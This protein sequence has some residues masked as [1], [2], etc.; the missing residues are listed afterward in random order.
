MRTSDARRSLQQLHCRSMLRM[1]FSEVLLILCLFQKCATETEAPVVITDSGNVAGTRIEIG[2]RKVDA[3][4]GIPYAEPP[5]GELRFQ[6]A[7]P[8]KPWNGTYQAT[9]KPTPCRQLLLPVFAGIT[10][11]YSSASEDCLYL[12]VW[13]P[14]SACESPESCE[15]NLPVVVFV[16]GNV[17][18][19]ADSSLFLNDPANFVALTDVVFVTFNYR[20][21]IFGFLSLEDSEIPGNMGLWDQNLV[22]KWVQANVRHFG[23]DPNKVTLSGQSAGA[24]SVGLHAISPHSKGLFKRIVIQSGSPLSLVIG[25][26]FRGVGK[27]TTITGALG[28][29]DLSK[30]LDEQKKQILSCLQKM[31]ASH[32]VDT[33]QRVDFIKQMFSPID[34]DDFLPA[35]VLSVDAYNSLGATEILLG[36]V[37]NEGPVFLSHLKLA[38]PRFE[39]LI[40]SEY[41]LVAILVMAQMLDI[42]VWQSRRIATA[43]FGGPDDKRKTPEEVEAIFA[44]MFGDVTFYCPS[45]IMA[46]ILAQQQGVSVYRY[47]FVHRP[48]YSLWPESFGVAH[49]DD[50]AFTTGSLVF[51]NDTARHTVPLGPKG[52]EALSSA[53]YTA[54]EKS[55]M[56]E[57]VTAWGTF[58]TDGKPKVPLTGGKWPRYTFDEPWVIYLQPNNY[59][60][61]VEPK[62]KICEVWKPVLLR[63]S[64]PEERSFNQEEEP[65]KKEE[66]KTNEVDNTGQTATS[67]STFLCSA[68]ILFISFAGLTLCLSVES[69]RAAVWTGFLLAAITMGLA[70]PLSVDIGRR[71]LLPV[72][73]TAFVLACIA[74][75]RLFAHGAATCNAVVRTEKGLIRGRC[76]SING[77]SVEA[78]LGVPYAVPPVGSLRFRRPE[79]AIRWRGILDATQM[80]KPCWQL[81]L[82]FLPNLTVDYSHMASED[83]LYLNVWKP[84]A[85]CS[86]QNAACSRKHPV[87]V[88]IHGGAFQW[89]DSSL[90][91]YNPSNFVALADVVFVSFNYRVGIFGFLDSK[92]AGIQGNIGLWDQNLVLKWIRRNID[93]FGGD[94]DE[95]TLLGQS[96]GGISAALHSLSPYSRGLFKRLVLQSGTPLSLILGIAFGGRAK[97][98]LTAL[99]M[100][101][102]DKHKKLE[103][104]G[105]AI[106]TCLRKM[107]APAIFEKLD[108][109]DM[110]QQMFPP[111]ENDDFIPGK[112]L[113][114]DTWKHL[115]AK[116]IL[117]GSVA[118][119]GTV[120]YNLLK[121]SIPIF[122]KLLYSDYR[123]LVSFLM[124]EMFNIDTVDGEKLVKGYFGDTTEQP[125]EKQLAATISRMLGD[126]V[127]T[128]PTVFFGQIAAEQGIHTYRYLFNY[129][130][131]HSLWPK[132]MGVAHAEDIAYTLGSLPFFKDGKL[133]AQHLGPNAIKYADRLHYTPEEEIFMKNIVQIWS[134]FVKT[135]K[136][137]LPP[138]VVEWPEYTLQNP[139]VIH[140]ELNKYT[141]ERDNFQNRC[142]LWK[143]ILLGTNATSPDAAT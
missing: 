133:L 13:R 85:P 83:C 73:C 109:L 64:K 68:L 125:S 56:E 4:L 89:G 15:V 9:Q 120:F 21:S 61:I 118:D 47:V 8:V 69:R 104:Q 78:Y 84:A 99:A 137:V 65:S 130:A 97:I 24:A 105:K 43:Y 140:I 113:S 36:T 108:S 79:P 40:L 112:V 22:L 111:S 93:R 33:V 98:I 44:E 11:N 110:T 136:P 82:R 53:R 60:T 114:A 46:D 116:E 71:S 107:D 142:S 14:A 29:Y 134:S 115:A 106:A 132:W 96:A 102:Y 129:R 39:D 81:P 62:R 127:F 1:V 135:G 95:V 42:P 80:P 2:D 86:S 66:T 67:P 50:L 30:T 117:L 52:R 7:R 58:Y 20:V 141:K 94:P 91:V 128:C 37:K 23:G 123:T 57:I 76:L 74:S 25:L 75:G 87:V 54:D 16:D 28:C 59:T 38:F 49:S 48:S 101:C 3:F 70:L 27:F 77:K 103:D 119:E 63:E 17:F 18:Q 34:G 131:T 51:V 10:L 121:E 32:I 45:Q 126:A 12:N 143:P 88:F 92:A 41:R 26:F 55:F 124:S 139:N 100:N 6:K 19:W 31:E 35:R 138:P 90:F 72:L 5:V 122:S